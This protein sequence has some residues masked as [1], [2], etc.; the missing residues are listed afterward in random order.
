MLSWSCHGEMVS[1]PFI[2]CSPYD[3]IIGM[4]HFQSHD[5]LYGSDVDICMMVILHW[6]NFTI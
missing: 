5:Q 2:S 4:L 1:E 6:M 3:Y